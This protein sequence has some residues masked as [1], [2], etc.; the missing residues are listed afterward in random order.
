MKAT[1]AE[2]KQY[3]VKVFFPVSP[4]T[5][6]SFTKVRPV[7]RT[8]ESKGVARFAIEQLIAGPTMTER[9]EGLID[10]IELTGESTCGGD[11]TISITQKTAK[12]QFCRTVPTAGIGDDARIKT[13]IEKTLTQFPTIEKVIIL[14]RNGNCFKDLSGK[15]LCL[16]QSDCQ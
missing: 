16:M 15:N 4:E 10:T 3:S 14:N 11:F 7:T 12:L 13:A 1:K 6:D 9:Q 8:T 2:S 5:S